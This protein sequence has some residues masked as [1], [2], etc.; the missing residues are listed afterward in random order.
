MQKRRMA[1]AAFLL[2]LGAFVFMNTLDNPRLNAVHGSDRLRLIAVGFCW[3]VGF[4]I[5]MSG[6]AFPGEDSRP[7]S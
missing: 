7:Q 6:R 5:L 2:L 3:G 1:I 4:G